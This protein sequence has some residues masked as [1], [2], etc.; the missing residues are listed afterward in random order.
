MNILITG[1]AGFIGFHTAQALI[2]RRDQVIIVDNLSQYYDVKLKKDRLQQL[3]DQVKYYHVDISDY[4]AMKT[5]FAENKIDKVIHLAAQAGVRY[6]IENPFEYEKNNNLGTLNILELMRHF[7]VKDLVFASSSS[8]Y[9]GNEKAPSSVEDNVDRPISLYAATKK[10]NELM[11]HVYHQLYGINCF[12]LR[13]FTV[14]GPWGRPDMM[15]FKLTKAILEDQTIDVYNH[16]KHQRDFTYITDIV[17]GILAALEHIK[18]YQIFNLG[19]NNPTDLMYYI[20]CVEKEL[21]KT[22]RKNFLPL[23]KGDIEKTYANI[24]KTKR[25]LGWEP[26][27]K[28][29]E[30]I[31]KFI[32]WYKDYYHIN[33]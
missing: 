33:G 5:V 3:G 19:N 20:S 14:Y 8:V 26:Q 31:Q 29:E 12:G 25:L 27:V 30:G 6:S 9:G 18:G 21:G 10:Y 17:A 16:G 2:K 24:E 1:G 4:Q 15:L 7:G 23:Q 28:V 11:V 22:A 13:F 32:K